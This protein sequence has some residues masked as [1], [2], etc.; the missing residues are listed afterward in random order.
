K[1]AKN[2]AYGQKDVK[3]RSFNRVNQDGHWSCKALCVST[4]PKLWQE[5]GFAYDSTLGFAD[6]AGFRCGVCYEYTM[7]DLVARAKMLLKQRPLI[8]MEVT[9]LSK[10]YMGLNVKNGEF[11]D[12]ID[13]LRTVV[14]QYNG[15]FTLLW[16]NYSSPLSLKL[17]YILW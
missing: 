13:S 8:F 16:H 9:G 4:T 10:Q 15:D 7:F 17:K 2:S 12:Y 1:L 14:K 11:S 5:N 6:H 3:K